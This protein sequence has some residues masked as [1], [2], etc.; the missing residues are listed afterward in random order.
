MAN[1]Q[2]GENLNIKFYK[3][4][5]D[6]ENLTKDIEILTAIIGGVETV[7]GDYDGFLRSESSI[8]DPVFNIETV[9]SGEEF[10]WA[11]VNYFYV[12]SWQRYYYITDVTVLRTHLYQITGHVDVLM[13]FRNDILNCSGLVQN[14]ENDW[15]MYLDDGSCRVFQ[16]P[17][18]LEYEFP[19]SFT[20]EE[21]VLAVAGTGVIT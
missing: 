14:N 16:D 19:S 11:R 1:E 12:P 5:S 21:F 15:N 10:P 6:K 17:H 2:G 7:I 8:V 9:D 13:S 20:A 3:C 18:V 4:H